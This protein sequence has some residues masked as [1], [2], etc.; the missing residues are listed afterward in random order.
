MA[1]YSWGAWTRTF[2]LSLDRTKVP[3]AQ[4][5]ES[6]RKSGQLPRVVYR[7]L[8][9]ADMQHLGQIG[10]TVTHACALLVEGLYGDLALA[11]DSAHALGDLPT[12]AD[13]EEQF[14]ARVEWI[15]KW[16]VLEI[17]RFW[18]EIEDNTD[19][20]EDL[21]GNSQTSSP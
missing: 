3:D 4:A 16:P 1:K 12:R 11:G 19:V 17:Q 8:T 7:G 9:H 14:Q 10:N 6:F 21:E 13:P 15:N 5:A 18:G 2:Y 20:P